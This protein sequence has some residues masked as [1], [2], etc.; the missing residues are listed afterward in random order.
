MPVI[1]VI[2]TVVLV[3]LGYFYVQGSKAPA[4]SGLEEQ[5]PLSN[6]VGISEVRLLE[7]IQSVQIDT[8]L[9]K[10]PAYQSLQDFSVKIPEQNVGRPNPF[11]PI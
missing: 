10:S 2:V 7:Q 8:S 11:A 3:M 5:D 4:S 6:D 9:F 1:A